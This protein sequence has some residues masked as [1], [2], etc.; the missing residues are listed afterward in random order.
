ME[1]FENL[2]FKESRPRSLVK[3]LIYRILAIFGTG[4][5]VWFITKDIKEVISTTIAIQAFLVILY[6]FNERVWNRIHWGRKIKE[7]E[8]TK[9]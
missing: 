5:I 8:I 4:V 2:V 9:I 6:Y 7:K 3:S 1:N